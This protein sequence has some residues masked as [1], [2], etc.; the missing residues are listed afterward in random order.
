MHIP[1]YLKVGCN[2]RKAP[3]SPCVRDSHGR[4]LGIGENPTFGNL[5]NLAIFLPNY[6]EVTINT[7]SLT[8]PL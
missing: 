7:H 8:Y 2:D 4:P 6:R 1:E 5:R 3:I